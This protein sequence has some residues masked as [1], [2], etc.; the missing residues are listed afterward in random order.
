MSD[1]EFVKDYREKELSQYVLAYLLIA[2]AFVGFHT[3]SELQQVLKS[4]ASTMPLILQMIMTDFFLGA[5][6]VLVVILNEIWPDRVKTRL[7]YWKIPSSTIFSRI[8]N[9]KLDAAGF[10]LAEAR[11]IYAHLASTPPDKQTS[12][13]NIL[14]R[15]CRKAGHSNVVDAQRMQLM[16]RD[17]CLSTL[18]LLIMS[19]AAVAALAIIHN[20]IRVSL[21]MLGFP[22]LY[23]VVMLVVT[24]AAARNRAHRLVALVIKND[25]QDKKLGPT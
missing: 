4:A 11:V 23:L 15:K 13:W 25:V 5:V 20:D 12:E 19:I 10:D 18:S 8:A 9:G 16:T 2:V 17:I 6:C 24:G 1:I 3:V 14:L 21:S 7:I 22:M